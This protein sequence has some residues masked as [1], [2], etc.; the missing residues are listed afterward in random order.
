MTLKINPPLG[1]F[2][3]VVSNPVGDLNSQSLVSFMN[4][5]DDLGGG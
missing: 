3:R 1:V 2:W 5:V 4:I